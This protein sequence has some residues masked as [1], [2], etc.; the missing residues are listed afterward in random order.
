MRSC[1]L[2][3]VGGQGT[4]LASRIIAAAAM[5]RGLF[6]RT[7]ETIGMAQR[8]GCVVS[9]VRIGEQVPSPLIPPGQ[10]DALLGFEPGETVRNLKYLKPDGVVIV[11]N[12]A[13]QPVTAALAGMD[14]NAETMLDYLK[15]HVKTCIVLDTDEIT[16]SCGSPKALNVAL[17]GAM[18]RSGVMGLDA[19]DIETAVR[20]R[21]KPRFLDMNL[22]ALQY[23]AD[24][25]RG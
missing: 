17:V 19:K 11:G 23:G 22:K 25:V 1:L 5:E 21:V 8:G 6:A 13:V 24:C 4:V 3:G 18:A 10:A 15:S 12:R 7:A 14:Y 2:C 20:A 9:H 16:R